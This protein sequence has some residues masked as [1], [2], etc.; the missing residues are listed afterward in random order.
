MT[1]PRLENLSTQF[2]SDGGKKIKKNLLFFIIFTNLKN[3]FLSIDV[4]VNP[5]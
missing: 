5:I 2:F 4:E 1:F 3:A